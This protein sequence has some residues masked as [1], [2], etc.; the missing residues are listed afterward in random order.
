MQAIDRYFDVELTEY[1]HYKLSN[2][3]WRILEGLEGVLVV[4]LVPIY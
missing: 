1:K 3:D 4:G 2:L